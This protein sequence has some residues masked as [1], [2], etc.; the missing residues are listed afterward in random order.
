MINSLL[1]NLYT[2]TNPKY[3]VATRRWRRESVFRRRGAAAAAAAENSMNAIIPCVVWWID[4]VT[5]LVF[6]IWAETPDMIS[7]ATMLWPHDRG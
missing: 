3:H 1:G 6:D 2:E 7:S 5:I 4:S